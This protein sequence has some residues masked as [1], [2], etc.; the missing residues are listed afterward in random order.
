MVYQELSGSPSLPAIDPLTGLS[1]DVALGSPSGPIGAI[2]GVVGAIASDIPGV[3]EITAIIGVLADLGPKLAALLKEVESD[4]IGQL[5]GNLGS[6]FGKAATYVADISNPT[7][8]NL[9]KH[10]VGALYTELLRDGMGV[11]VGQFDSAQTAGLATVDSM[12]GFAF[13]VS[14]ICAAGEAILSAVLGARAP[15]AIMELLGE[16]PQTM[17]LTW[18]LGMQLDRSFETAVGASIDEAILYQKRPTRFEWR[19][20]KQLFKQHV[21]TDQATAKKF[22][23]QLGYRSDDVDLLMKLDEFAIPIAELAR[24]FE[25]NIVGR[26]DILKAAKGQGYTDDEAEKI[27]QLYVDHMETQTGTMYRSTAR[28]LFRSGLITQGDYKGILQQTNTPPLEI[29][30]DIA[31]IDLEHSTGRISTTVGALKT[32]YQHGAMTG[33][34]VTPKLAQLGYSPS[35]ISDLLKSWDEGPLPHGM[36]TAKIL[37]YWYS[38]VITSRTTAFDDLI[39]NHL[40]PADANFLLDHPTASG[41]KIHALTPAL[42]TQA[43]LDGAIDE[44][45]LEAALVKLKLTGDVLTYQLA[46]AKFKKSRLKRPA[47]STIALTAAEIR[48]AFKYNLLS[49][50]DALVELEHLGY[51]ADNALLLVDIT[52]KGL[53]TPPATPLFPS[54][55][56][57][58]AF[59]RSLGFQI[60]GPPDPRVAAAEG[61][62]AAAGYSFAPP[63]YTP[64]TPL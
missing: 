8:K 64:P 19:V 52:N 26:G 33:A 7:W 25:Y 28:Q 63:P 20:I 43:Y 27:T 46:V 18:A 32:Q 41:A 38:G 1:P 24:M 40:R 36:T 55:D 45:G 11:D 14:A 30:D 21:I 10:S 54:V 62:V 22:I 9:E 37:S 53:V 57:A 16:I 60:F 58:M 12:L 29:A 4:D 59:L 39:K 34:E 48:E 6:D 31:A 61:M 56:Q 35:G 51:S 17:G 3:K 44:G 5:L 15:K 13:G 23:E 2:G 42:A 47:G 49:E 50:A